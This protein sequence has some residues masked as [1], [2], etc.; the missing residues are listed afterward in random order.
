MEIVLDLLNAALKSISFMTTFLII[1]VVI[2][3]L[4]GVII[5]SK[6]E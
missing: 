4:I 5:K 3:G 1:S 6:H 2:H